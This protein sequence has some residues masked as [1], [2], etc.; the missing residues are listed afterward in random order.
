M[1]LD[2]KS[3]S[4]EPLGRCYSLDRKED[5]RCANLRAKVQTVVL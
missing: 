1:A 3:V 2:F 5:L 4:Y